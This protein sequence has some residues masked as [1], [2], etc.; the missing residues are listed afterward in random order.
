MNWEEVVSGNA[1]LAGIHWILNSSSS[2]RM[3]RGEVQ[4]MLRPGY[5]VGPFHLT[6]A[7]FK[8]GRKLS[9]H[10]TLPVI[11]AESQTSH[12]VHL[13]VTW[14]NGAGGDGQANSWSQL[15]K[16]ADHSG[17]MPVQCEL[18][19]EN[20]E[21][22]TKFQIWPFDPEFPHLIRLGNP[23]YV[24]QMFKS[25]GIASNLEKV[26]VVT[27]IRYRP[28]ERHV[29]R[30]EI[31]SPGT[32]SEERQRLYAKL[33]TSA[34]EAAK[35]YGIARRVVDWL[36]AN[37]QGLQGNRPIAM[38][39][40]NC[41]ILYPHVPGIPLSHQLHRSRRWLSSQ[42]QIIGKS[43]AVLHNGPETLQADLKHNTFANEVK[44]VKRASEHIKVFLPATHAKI[45]E[46]V[47]EAQEQYTDLPQEEP[48][49]THSDF[50]SDHLLYTA[51]RL[52]LIDFDT[53]TLTDPALDIGK[54]LADLEWW[55]T[56]KGISGVEDAQTM[57]LNGYFAGAGSA[58]A[59]EE[60]LA[61]ARFFQVL[62]LIKIVVRRVPLY[63]KEWAAKTAG[64]IDRA[65]QLLRK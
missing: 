30:Y 61:R 10:F 52:T 24:D 13:T 55:F 54:F 8:P 33:Y 20:P 35:A 6:R 31:E 16:E 29:L 17:L 48:T 51:E 64:M 45:L 47:E 11:D 2:R 49:F 58:Q 50:K 18:W 23:S 25:L 32:A 62:I 7:K 1:G 27:P 56:L 53:C 36:D 34:Q 39:P 22:G 43:L 14:Q 63:K 5:Y 9:A 46:A 38:S 12:A 42:L 21:Q 65:V 44:V 41:V 28:G 40:E 26:P 59:I 57:L 60:R 19:R 4:K 37:S 15:Q 3:L